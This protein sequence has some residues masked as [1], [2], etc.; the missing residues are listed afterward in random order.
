M[1]TEI[2]IIGAILVA[3]CAFPFVYAIYEGKKKNRN[4]ARKL[5]EAAVNGGYQ[6]NQIDNTGKI[7]IGMDDHAGKLFFYKSGTSELQ[8]SLDLSQIR[9]CKVLNE[10][11]GRET[12]G[13]D[14]LQRILLLF[15]FKFSSKPTS[16]LLFDS[17]NDWQMNGELAIAEKWNTIINNKLK[18]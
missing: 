16:F 1:D 9:S 13:Q 4:M 2:I 8:E 5:Q 12:S 11:S 6:I 17:D 18:K 7:A 10:S 15:T 14:N 3:I